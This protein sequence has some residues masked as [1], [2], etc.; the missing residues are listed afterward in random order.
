VY[1][2]PVVCVAAL[3]Q[4]FLGEQMWLREDI[5]WLIKEAERLKRYYM[6]T[7]RKMSDAANLHA[8]PRSMA[9]PFPDDEVN[10]AFVQLRIAEAL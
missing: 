8:L 7:L 9:E 5:G 2:Q 4:E 3:L 6:Y 10:T 1:D